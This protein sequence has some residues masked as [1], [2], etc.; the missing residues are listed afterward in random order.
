M[1]SIKPAAVL[2]TTLVSLLLAGCEQP[3]VESVPLTIGEAGTV[4]DEALPQP[5][6][7]PSRLG[8]ELVWEI[9]STAKGE[10]YYLGRES[11]RYYDYCWSSEY[12][13]ESGTG[14]TLGCERDGLTLL[15]SR[16]AVGEAHRM[17]LGS[18]LSAT[19]WR[20]QAVTDGP[21]LGTLA[22]LLSQ[23]EL[24]P[25]ESYRLPAFDLRQQL[26]YELTLRVGEVELVSTNW[27]EW[28]CLPV[29][30]TP[31]GITAYLDEDGQP[32][33][34]RWSEGYAELREM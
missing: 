27:G 1:R 23:L 5:T 24:A 11:L 3:I 16:P 29:E 33:L 22:V 32:W 26:G 10:P 18:L 12:T 34:F 8:E 4:L 9:F 13:L 14:L 6:S 28:L 31:L 17:L 2:F 21:G 30:L 7:T 20:Y 19:T 15:L 25:V